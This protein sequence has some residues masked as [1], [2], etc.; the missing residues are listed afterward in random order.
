MYRI[1]FIESGDY[2]YK[3]SRDY[4]LGCSSNLFSSYEVIEEGD[5][6][7]KTRFSIYEFNTKEEA[8]ASLINTSAIKD[9]SGNF[10][11]PDLSSCLFEIV[12]V[13]DV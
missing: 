11:R 6:D 4:N 2:L 1:L 5:K 8:Y 9:C 10:I 13:K 12:E 3:Y 7:E